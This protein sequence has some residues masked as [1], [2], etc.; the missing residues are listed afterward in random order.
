MVEQYLFW[1]WVVPGAFTVL[2]TL[3]VAVAVFFAWVWRKV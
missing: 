1:T 3:V 2:G